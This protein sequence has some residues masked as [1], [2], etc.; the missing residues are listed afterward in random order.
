MIISQHACNSFYEFILAKCVTNNKIVALSTIHNVLEFR[1][2][3][4]LLIVNALLMLPC[5]TMHMFVK[6]TFTFKD[7]L[8]NMGHSQ[9]N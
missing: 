9:V 2:I 5:C 6:Y 8:C 3:T 7:I 4:G 1:I